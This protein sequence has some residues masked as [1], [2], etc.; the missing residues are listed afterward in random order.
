MREVINLLPIYYFG[1]FFCSALGVFSNQK[2]ARSGKK[3]NNIHIYSLVS[4]LIAMAFFYVSSG[5]NINI[6]F[7]TLIYSVIFA[8]LIFANYF[9]VL[10]VFR[11]MG[12]AEKTFI[13]SGLSLIFTMIMGVVLFNEVPSEK[14]AVQL[15]LVLATLFVIFLPTLKK[16]D[17]KKMVTAIGVVLCLGITVLGVGCTLV[18]KYFAEDLKAG[19]VTD[20]NSFFFLTNVFIVVFGICTVMISQKGSVKAVVKEFKSVSPFNYFMIVLNVVSSNMHSLLQMLIFK[21]GDLILY[22]PLNGAL[23]LLAGEVVAVVFAK[24]KPRILATILA[25]SSVLVV[26]LF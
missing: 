2:Y 14:T 9:L 23:G 3:I 21:E 10:I 8:L 26:L 7:R 19:T 24:E 16:K 4:G 15:V 12:I 17:A 22:A 6:N 5:F 18:A 11:H 20:E 1:C 25:L 13:C